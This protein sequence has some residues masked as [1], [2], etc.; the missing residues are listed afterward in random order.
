MPIT[1]LNYIDKLF[2]SKPKDYNFTLSASVYNFSWWFNGEALLITLNDAVFLV[3]DAREE[4]EIRLYASHILSSDTV[5]RAIK[6]IM[7]ILGLKEDL[8]EFYSIMAR[9][10]LLS[11]SLKDLKGMHIRASTPWI[12][13]VIGVCQQNISFKLGWRMFYNFVRLLGKTV[14]VE[15]ITTYVPPTPVEIEDRV[16]K[17]KEVGF[18]YRFQAILGIAKMFNRDPSLNSWDVNPTY[19]EDQMLE[20][21]GVGSY[22]SRLTLALSLRVYDK[23]PMDK[24]LRKL[25]SEVYNVSEKDVEQFYTGIWGRW[26]GLAA[27]YTTVALDAEP[28]TKAL[29]RVKRKNLK[30]DPRRFSP[31]TMWRH[32]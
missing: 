6:N 3:R 17:L 2:I 29:E 24:W 28:L 32:L 15:G 14:E 1:K 30:P 9:D 13:A 21:K 11:P 18:G 27:L 22:T 10:P 26:S 25:A 4:L 16:D 23:P 20:V 19:L 8:S 12:A 5:D 31:L 7:H